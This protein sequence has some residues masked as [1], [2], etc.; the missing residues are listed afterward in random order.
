MINISS[1][2]HT[3]PVHVL[4]G[5]CNESKRLDAYFPT[6]DVCIKNQKP[7]NVAYERGI[8]SIGSDVRYEDFSA[9]IDGLV[10]QEIKKCRSDFLSLTEEERITIIRYIVFQLFRL[11]V[12]IKLVKNKV[13]DKTI[14]LRKTLGNIELQYKL[15]RIILN[16]KWKIFETK[17]NE[18]FVITD[19]PVLIYKLKDGNEIYILYPLSN[20]LCLI[21]CDNAEFFNKV[22]GCYTQQVNEMLIRY[23]K[24][25]II[26]KEI[27]EN[28]LSFIRTTRKKQEKELNE[29][30]NSFINRYISPM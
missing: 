6:K 3:L 2:H 8:N 22:Q 29:N 20:H 19:F 11:P 4:E 30:L 5:F 26:A 21:A 25:Y 18:F 14:A 1:K 27:S 15:F 7:E 23:A 17:D 9:A 28:F 16:W 10:A 13:Y 12:L 24:Q